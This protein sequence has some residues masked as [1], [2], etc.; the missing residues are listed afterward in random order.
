MRLQD[1]EKRCD[2]WFDKL[3]MRAKSLKSLHLILSLSKDEAQ[4]SAFFSNLLV[5]YPGPIAAPFA[6][7]DTTRAPFRD[8][9]DPKRILQGR[10]VRPNAVRRN[11]PAACKPSGSM[12]CPRPGLIC[13]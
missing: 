12:P 9:N 2:P 13:H 5:A 3:T 6:I 10:A 8:D 4:I 1:A 11:M 7:P